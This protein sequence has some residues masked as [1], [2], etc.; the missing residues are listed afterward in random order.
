MFI[1]SRTIVSWSVSVGWIFELIT[2]ILSLDLD[3]IG[4]AISTKRELTD[5]TGTGMA[6]AIACSKMDFRPVKDFL[7]VPWTVMLIE[8]VKGLKLWWRAKMI[9]QT[10]F[11]RCLKLLVIFFYM[12]IMSIYSFYSRHTFYEENGQRSV[13]VGSGQID[14]CVW[15]DAMMQ[16]TGE[17]WTFAIAPK[18]S[19]RKV[20][21]RLINDFA[22][23]EIPSFMSLKIQCIRRWGASLHDI[24]PSKSICDVDIWIHRTGHGQGCSLHV[25][26]G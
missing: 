11:R 15:A 14:G 17:T 8:M 13:Q 21:V 23:H 6:S 25:L 12:D 16:Q 26:F 24:F 5:A 7:L 20:F 4:G 10:Q 19:I 3:G 18:T 2:A 9:N 1:F 22:R